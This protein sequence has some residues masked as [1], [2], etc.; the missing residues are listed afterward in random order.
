MIHSAEKPSP[1]R[2]EA[3]PFLMTRLCT[4]QMRQ[5]WNSRWSSQDSPMTAENVVSTTFAFIRRLWC[6][7]KGCVVAV[8]QRLICVMSLVAAP[9]PFGNG[10]YIRGT[11]QRVRLSW[12][13]PAG[14]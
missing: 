2:E 7:P 9:T 3:E 14:K 8:L 10:D 4:Y 6:G 13:K 11:P 1:P 12:K 5:S